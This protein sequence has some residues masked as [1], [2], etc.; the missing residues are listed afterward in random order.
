MDRRGERP[1]GG[2]RLTDRQTKILELVALGRENKEIAFELGVSEQSVKEQVSRL[3]QLLA[4]P[5]RAALGDA[6]ATRRLSGSFSID[7]DWL[8][9]LF[10]DAPVHAAIVSGHEHVF[11]AVNDAYQVASG[12]RALIGI[13]Y[14]DAFPD[15][16]QS[17]ESLDHAY[18]TGERASV[19]ELPSRFMRA[20]VA[21][22][23]LVAEIL[24]PLPGPDGRI[25]G[26]AIFSIDVT[27]NVRARRR[28]EELEKERFAILDAITSAIVVT[29]PDGA[30][31]M[32]NEAAR[33]LLSLPTPP[34][35]LATE[36]ATTYDLRD[37]ADGRRV[38]IAQVPVFRA[39]R[40]DR[41]DA[42]L[43]QVHDPKTGSARVLRVTSTP[44]LDPGGS[45]RG[46]VTTFI[47]E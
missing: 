46:S 38:P 11:V 5:N 43:Y 1:G 26:I 8:R 34:V 22:D 28:V 44:L 25:A 3:L 13:R 47:E 16:R 36:L 15:R 9:F 7:P 29:D 31:V 21:E 41:V 12:S 27:D 30:V 45:V 18:S 6:A 4:A 32:A 10:Q 40:G 33:R 42:H 17:L 24:Q 37:A 35:T 14:A 20:G 39:L 23:G 19:S 2:R